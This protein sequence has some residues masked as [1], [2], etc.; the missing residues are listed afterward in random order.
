MMS[1]YIVLHITYIFYLWQSF[2]QHSI[3]TWRW[4]LAVNS[5]AVLAARSIKATKDETNWPPTEQ[6][7]YWEANIFSASQEIPNILWN[8]KFHYCVYKCVPVV[9]ILS[10]INSVQFIF[11]INFSIILP[12][13]PRCSNHLF[14]AGFSTKIPFAF[15]FSPM[16][17]TYPAHLL[18]LNLMTLI[19]CGKE[20]KKTWSSSLGSFHQLPCYFL[21][22]RPK[23]LAQHAILEH[24][25]YIFSP[26]CVRTSFTPT[27]N[28]R[29]D[30]CFFT[31]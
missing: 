8:T 22:L 2:V 31:V 4:M 23:C 10:Q 25:Q 28:N 14:L 9:P 1:Y 6:S 13:I 11:Y 21:H 19:I 18:L 26:Q 17:T 16:H 12:Y 30:Q 24:P 15:L 3:S 27:Q 5:F 29:Q 20:L 7:F